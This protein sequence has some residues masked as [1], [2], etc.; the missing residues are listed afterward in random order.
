MKPAA[1]P[2]GGT[3]PLLA[4]AS[5]RLGIAKSLDFRL[6]CRTWAASVRLGGGLEGV[7]G[8]ERRENADARR[9][10]SVQVKVTPEELLQLKAR[11]KVKRV[12]VPRLLFESAMNVT[13]QMDSDRWEAAERLLAMARDLQGVSTNVNQLAKFANTEG[14]FPV[15]AEAAVVEVRVL[16]RALQGA[17]EELMRR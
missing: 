3:Y 4:G 6:W 10:R 9:S 17:A 12:S 14:V 15:E 1:G 5:Y 13:I 8:R 16:T 11:A 7:V 2:A